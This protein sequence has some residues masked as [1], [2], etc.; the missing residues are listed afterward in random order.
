MVTTAHRKALSQK[1]LPLLKKINWSL[2]GS[3]ALHG[4]FFTI[5]L[6]ELGL[7]SESGDNLGDTPVI[8]LNAAEQQRLP[9]F[10]NNNQGFY[11][12]NNINPVPQ[13]DNGMGPIPIP[14]LN[15]LQ[16]P[17]YDDNFAS[18]PAPPP[19]PSQDGFN[20][21]PPSFNSINNIPRPINLPAPPP[22]DT[23]AIAP[24]P[25]SFNNDPTSN[26]NNFDN[27]LEGRVIDIVPKSPEEE[28]E[29]RRAIF[30]GRE[31]INIP[32]A[33]DV[34]NNRTPQENPTIAANPNISENPQ[35]NP[36]ANQGN[37]SIDINQ[38][39]ENLTKQEENTSDEE[40]RKNYVA[41]LQDVK[42]PTPKEI[43]ITANYPKDACV[44]QIEGTATYGINVTPEGAITDTK[45]IKSSGYPLFNN[46]AL[47][48]I[49]AKTFPNTTSANQPYHVYVNFKHNP[50]I[51]PSLSVS[52]AGQIPTPTAPNPEAVAT[53]ENSPNNTQPSQSQTPSTPPETPQTQTPTNPPRNTQ[54]SQPQTP[55]TQVNPPSNDNQ[56]SQ[57]ARDLLNSSPEE[58]KPT[59]P[60]QNTNEEL[61]IINNNSPIELK[62]ENNS[63]EK[64]ES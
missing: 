32:D 50:E 43:T 15:S 27:N 5:L 40:A 57:S 54:P 47:Q 24:L 14:D 45:L 63:P 33:R 48:E 6:P 62:L 37:S 3:I 18:L 9:Q 30:E 29:I 28:R 17:E 39:R 11:N 38:M 35:D 2:F 59:S 64:E 7:N 49:Q 58:I 36:S 60:T 12:W 53:P 26:I 61:N 19:F 22:I 10:D 8:E 56:P 25:P 23:S 52:N 21:T 31:N 13:F 16:F 41:W 34:F 1:Q 42:N 51:C 46:R 20:Y 55:P 44:T 4:V